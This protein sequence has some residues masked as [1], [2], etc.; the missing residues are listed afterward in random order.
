MDKSGKIYKTYVQT[1]KEELIPAMGCTEPIAI[2]YAAAK[3]REVLGCEPDLVKIGVSNNI[4][5]NVKSVVVPNTDGMKGIEAA[6]V[7]GILGGNAA[8]ELEVIS[9]VTAN[10]KAAMR[11]FLSNVPISV[12]AIDNG[13]IFDIIIALYCGTDSAV[14]RISQYHTNIVY[15]KKNDEVLLDNTA[16][17]T[18][19]ACNTE[20]ESG[21][22]DRSL[23]TIA[24]IYDFAETCD[25]D[26]VRPLLDTQILYNTQISEE[27]LLGDYGANVGSTYLKFYG[28]DVRNRAIAKAAAGSDARMSGCELPVVINSGSGNQGITVSVPVIEYAKALACPKERLYRALVLSNLI[29]IHEKTGIGRLSAYCGAT[30]AACAAAVGI[31]WLQG[32][33]Y[34]QICGV[35]T[36]TLATLGGMWCDGAK[37]SCASKIAAAV[38]TGLLSVRMSMNGHR[39]E[40]GEGIVTASVEK[41]IQDVG[42]IA[43]EG[44]READLEIL[45]LMLKN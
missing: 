24:N 2:A 42:H 8:K 15:I 36:N 20:A 6:A 4:I 10:Q 30:S 32:G 40:Q 27:G 13:I 9:E 39:F 33:S 35:I 3:A 7:A 28:N 45:R 44:M 31:C 22:T 37:S 19:A 17:Q 38:Y 29:A 25:L 14:V 11:R 5:K 41:T 1:L 18:S 43:R 12:E 23:L 34:E 21:L 26:D 16:R